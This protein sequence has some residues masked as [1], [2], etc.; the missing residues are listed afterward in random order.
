MTGEKTAQGWRKKARNSKKKGKGA[1]RKEKEEEQREGNAETGL[2]NCTE[3]GK[4]NE[5]GKRRERT[6][7]RW[8]TK[9]WG[10]QEKGTE[11]GKEREE[12][13]PWKRRNDSRNG[14]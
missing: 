14:R 3:S 9:A 5:P 12:D 4:G 1:R 11:A 2:E 8:K 7:P 10:D 13:K 6:T